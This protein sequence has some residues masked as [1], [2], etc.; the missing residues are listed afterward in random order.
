MVR[1][2]FTCCRSAFRFRDYRP[3]KVTFKSVRHWLSQFEAKDQA[4]AAKLLDHIVFL[5][6]EETRKLLVEQ[7]AALVKRLRNDGVPPK[8]LIYVQVHDAGSSSP[9][10][11]NLLRDSAGLERMGCQFVDSRDALGI[12]RVTNKYGDGAIIYVDD[13]AGTGNQFCEAREFVSKYIVGKNFPEFLLIPAICEEAVYKLGQ[14]GVEPIAGYLHSK[15][16][17]PLHAHCTIMDHQ[18]KERF[19]KLCQG[20]R[21]KMPLGYKELA[22]MVVLYRNAPNSIPVLFR[23]SLNQK[24]FAGI[25]PR[26]TDLPTPDF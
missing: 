24:P 7:N 6:E 3:Q 8:K 14:K 13:F 19:F 18:T 4:Q 15:A 1:K 11:L 16:E 9:V 17:R 12:N 20:I 23:G 5:S 26:T 10:M 21:P 22:T 2:F 25:F